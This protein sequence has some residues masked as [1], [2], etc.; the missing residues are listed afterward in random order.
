MSSEAPTGF[1]WGTEIGRRQDGAIPFLMYTPR[2]RHLIELL[3]DVA[4]WPGRTLVVQGERRVHT[5]QFLGAVAEL[6][7]QLRELGVGAGDRV[8]LLA[9]NSPEWMVSFWAVAATGAIVVP[10]NGW[11]SA[12]ETAH[13]VGLVEPELVICDEARRE[14]L[15]TNVRR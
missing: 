6:A 5:E 13:A 9:P 1:A 2:R 12:A 4:R 11:W 10:G 15:G 14:R 7:A 3:D 8:L